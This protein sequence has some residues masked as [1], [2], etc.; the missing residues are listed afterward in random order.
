MVNPNRFL[1]GIL[2]NIPVAIYVIDL[3]N[4]RLLYFNR[5][6]FLGFSREECE[7]K[8]SL[9]NSVHPDDLDF[10]TGTWNAIRAGIQSDPIEY[11][12]KDKSGK[13]HWVEQGNQTLPLSLCGN[14]NTLVVTVR[15]ITEQ[16]NLE[17]LVSQDA[18]EL[19]EIFDTMTEGVALN[20]MIFNEKGEQIDYKILRV[21]ST[22]YKIADFRGKKVI[23]NTATNLYGMTS[24]FIKDFWKVHQFNKKPVSS[25]MLSP[26]N[27]RY[28][29]ISTSPFRNGR[30]L[31]VFSDITEQKKAIN[32]IVESELKFKSVFENSMDAVLLT[33]PDGRILAVNPSGCKMFGYSEQEICKKGRSLI[34]SNSDPKTHNALNQRA[35]RGFFSGELTGIRKNGEEFPVEI[36]SHLF[37]D[38]NGEPRTSTIIRDITKQKQVEEELRKSEENL[39]DLSRHLEDARENERRK[40]SRDLHDDLG[41]KLTAILLQLANL[42]SDIQAQ[43]PEIE[44][45]LTDISTNIS[46][47]IS[48]LSSLSEKIYPG[49][50]EILGIKETIEWQVKEFVRIT[51]IKCSCLIK[52][53]LLSLDR[54]VALLIYRIIQESMTNIISHSAASEVIID[55]KEINNRIKLRISDNGRGISKDEVNDPRSYGLVG[56]RE[57]VT[58][59]GGTFR[60]EG[61]KGT[62]TLISVDI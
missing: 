30:F 32:L 19:Q 45:K 23:G 56:M 34:I 44:S 60:I 37:V 58:A 13:L 54:R 53:R 8:N 36:K 51:G 28:Y 9:L 48:S 21:N 20:E 41:Q 35:S 5:D 47:L 1:S 16:K 24:D 59:I 50:I 6:S 12:M 7:S 57:R 15:D 40:I 22:F 55:L 42:K 18:A 4:R 33:V 2:K 17:N 43:S 14:L 39:R 29:T 26:L 3:T 38:S 49:I 61:M 31:T 10:V 46:Y 62:G 11:R 52:T 27:H 25:E